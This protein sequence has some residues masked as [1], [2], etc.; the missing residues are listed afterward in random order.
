L[1]TSLATISTVASISGDLD[2]RLDTLESIN[3][4]ENEPTGF[5]NRTDSTIS[6]NPATREFAL[7]GNYNVWMDAVKYP[8]TGEATT[9]TATYGT[10]F[11]KYGAGGVFDVSATPWSLAADATIAYVFFNSGATDSFVAE[12]RHGITMDGATHYYLHFT[13][14]AKWKS[15]G[16][17]GDYTLNSDTVN[18]NKY[19]VSATEFFDEDILNTVA[20]QVDSGTY[21]VFYRT[22]AS[23]EWTWS[24]TE[25]YPY[26]INTN[27]IR[28][29]EFTGGNWQLTNI[30]TNNRW[31]NY[32]VFATNALTSGFGIIIVPG[33][34][35]HTSL[36]LAQAES[37]AS[38]SLGTL[39]FAEIV[40]LA[41]I[42]HQF[43]N[44]YANANGRARIVAVA[45][46]TSTSF[47]A[48]INAS[49]HNSLSGLQ[50]GAAGEYYHLTATQSD[51]WIGRTEVTSI[52][53]S[54]ESSKQNNITLVAG[55]NVSITESPTDTWTINASI[56]GGS[57]ANVTR[58]RIML[59][60]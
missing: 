31:V 57:G 4:A 58:W 13:Q 1:A 35:I 17:V 59:G 27:S 16:T 28:F 42:T 6:Y 5:E 46:L 53:G 29:N 49:S 38:L 47:A 18:N 52:S 54:L 50:G 30:T 32:Y 14:G 40:P 37:L 56:S 41:R 7:T 3:Y 25:A 21:N 24:K 19:S 48:A 11:I 34:A 44:A 22:G 8:K 12:E 15:G 55:S 33:Q 20:A 10:Q 43:S 23:G 9:L 45:S 2:A 36:A 26:L 51:D 39:P 60:A